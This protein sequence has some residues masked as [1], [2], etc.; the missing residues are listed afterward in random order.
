MYWNYDKLFPSTID[1]GFGNVQN[2]GLKKNNVDFDFDDQ[3]SESEQVSE[4]LDDMSSLADENSMDLQTQSDDM[5]M[6]STGDESLES[7]DNITFS[8]MF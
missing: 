8:N 6:N 7:N 5:T 1:D 4:Y 2:N 3:D